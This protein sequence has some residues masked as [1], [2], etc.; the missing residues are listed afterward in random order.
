MERRS[1]EKEKKQERGKKDVRLR[2]QRRPQ[3]TFFCSHFHS[4]SMRHIVD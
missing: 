1:N 3:P 4:A 2:C